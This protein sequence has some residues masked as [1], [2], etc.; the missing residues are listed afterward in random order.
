MRIF[1][2][3]FRDFR[4]TARSAFMRRISTY[5]KREDNICKERKAIG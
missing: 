1:R 5:L 2:V 4:T 3:I